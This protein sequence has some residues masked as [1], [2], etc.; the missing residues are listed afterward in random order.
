MRKEKKWTES[1]KNS[2]KG[3][4]EAGSENGKREQET[5]AAQEGIVFHQVSVQFHERL[6]LDALTLTIHPRERLALMGPS[7][8]G[9]STLLKLIAGLVQ[10]TQGRV[11][12]SGSVSMVFDQ[13]ELYPMLTGFENIEMGVDFS[14]VSRRIRHDRAEYWAKVFCCE[15]FMNQKSRTLSAGQRKPRVW[16]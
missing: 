7:G 8:A 14:K 16:G 12:C 2:Q 10:P 1:E 15:G 3:L 9:K 6:I 11:V 4:L 5:G 13:D